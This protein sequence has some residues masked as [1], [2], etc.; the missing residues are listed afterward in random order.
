MPFAFD[1]TLRCRSSDR[2]K[3]INQCQSPSPSITR[4]GLFTIKEAAEVLRIPISWLH[5]RTRRN[6]I[7]Y[8]R[9]GK[10]VRFTQD[11]LKEIASSGAQS[12]P[13]QRGAIIRRGTTFSVK[14]RTRTVIRRQFV[15]IYPL[16]LLI[17]Q[18]AEIQPAFQK[19]GFG[20]FAVSRT[21]DVF[22]ENCGLV[23]MKPFPLQIRNYLDP[24]WCSPKGIDDPHTALRVASEELRRHWARAGFKRVNGTDYGA[25]CPARGRPSSKRIAEAIKMGV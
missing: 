24:R 15:D 22:G 1:A 12:R 2:R 7:P 19:H 4:C 8:R 3:R 11:E 21:I 18:H 9:I 6:A 25:L 5:E 10:Y 13:R 17:L 20:L 16:D 14:Y 23:A